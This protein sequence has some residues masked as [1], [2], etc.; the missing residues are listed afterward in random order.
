MGDIRNTVAK[1]NV[2]LTFAAGG[3]LRVVKIVSKL[4][5]II[6]SDNF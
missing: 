5:K 2:N 4:L 1:C 6:L 3:G